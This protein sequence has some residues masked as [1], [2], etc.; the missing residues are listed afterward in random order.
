MKKRYLRTR[1]IIVMACLG[2]FSSVSGSA[3]I[4]LTGI[5]VFACDAHGT[6]NPALRFNSGPID[7][8]WD[9]FVAPTGIE[10][11][12]SPT[13]LNREDN[14]VR[15]PLEPGTHSF[16]LHFDSPGLERF[17]GVNLFFGGEEALPR[18]SAYVDTQAADPSQLRPNSAD[19]T[20]GL[21]IA[22]IPGAG[23]LEFTSGAAGFWTA[24]VS[25]AQNLRVALTEFAIAPPAEGGLDLVGQ[26]AASPSGQP[27]YVARITL[28][29]T[30]EPRTPMTI[31]QWLRSKAGMSTFLLPES[32]PEDLPAPP[33]DVAM[34][35]PFS[36]T[37]GEQSSAAV[38]PTWN[39]SQTATP[40][41]DA[42]AASV[43]TY[44]D[45]QT[46]LEV[47]WEGI[48]YTD[49]PAVE[50]VL[51]FK[52]TGK[53]NTPILSNI[54]ALNVAFEPDSAA[55]YR[56]HHF[57]GG[58]PDAE[59]YRPYTT[60]LAPSSS[61]SLSGAEGRPSNKDMPFFNVEYGNEGIVAAVAW[62]GQWMARLARNEKNGLGISA[63]QE[64]TRFTLYPGE[65]VR[66]PGIVLLFWKGGDWIDAQNLW[67][68][69]MMAHGMPKPGG[70]LPAPMLL[71][72]SSRAYEEMHGANEQN[73]IMFISRYLEED[74]GL[75]Y[76]WMDAGWYPCEGSWSKVGT[77]EVDTTRFPNGLKPISDY[78]HAHGIKTLLWFE[79]ERV[80]PGR[81]LTLN[82]PEWVLGGEGG[83]LL[84]LG[85]PEVREWLTNHVDK[86]LADNGIDLYRQDFNMEPLPYWEANDTGDRAG[87]S[88][89]RHVTNYL[90]Y[91]D[92]LLR[93]HPGMLI[94][95]CASGGRRN[96]LE[97]L[98]RAVPLWRSDYAYEPIGHQ[99]MT[100]GLS[101]LLP[102]HGTGTVA[103]VDAPYYGA[104]K[105]PVQPYA[106][107]SN[108]CPAIAC[109]FD[110]RI[111]DLDYDAL[112]TL[113]Q[114]W[115]SIAPYYYGDFYPLTPYTIEPD[116]WMAWQFNAPESG[117]GFVQ[118]FRR[119]KN[120]VLGI[121]M[122]LRGL[123][124]DATYVLES[125][126]KGT[127]EERT[128]AQLMGE[129]LKVY[130]DE[131][132]GY[133]VT[134]YEKKP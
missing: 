119:H 36:F 102:Y 21:P 127:R 132:P 8:A 131:M 32:A 107:W 63:G 84:N 18:I 118:A 4:A 22:D 76:W 9:L 77:W 134:R 111:K 96:D 48:Q 112:R 44:T 88:E 39:I 86:L 113:F 133:E 16:V 75:D 85:D 24:G 52:N 108:A 47:R 10:P 72:S 69:W 78:A 117:G 79:P 74:L 61:T 3:E 13:W 5:T 53:A 6:V 128:G 99:G 122:R 60:E 89:I 80:T 57:R 94:D 17:M 42:R 23:T 7:P 65:Q 49:F 129:G 124:A 120:D 37:Y 109:G 33:I 68:R 27:D 104:G 19:K 125:F 114:Q 101:F 26:N 30:E 97:T 43:V 103:H 54:Q 55:S 110:M 45:A 83:G 1:F 56:L 41:D 123:D 28:A 70:E 98:R 90:A 12:A 29:V 20:H 73:Q 115:R 62:P 87:M 93:R 35:P 64:N 38:L 46:G 106:F 25:G 82:H 100:Y 95:T 15:I 34:T 116:A 50:W 14:R 59:A 71:A 2:V 40:M 67:R 130:I 92:E 81:W 66:T 121:Q 58:L 11:A 126:G 91:W 31:I 51:Y 105:T